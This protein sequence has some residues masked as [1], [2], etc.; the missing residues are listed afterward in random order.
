MFTAQVTL[1]DADTNYSLL[2]LVRAIDANYIDRGTVTIQAAGANTGDV[3]IGDANLAADRYGLELASG[4]GKTYEV[5]ALA[6]LY[7]R[8]AAA[9]QKVNIEVS[10]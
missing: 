5:G 3:L 10:R 2:A 4:A 7:A 9:A 6:G 1:T 8:S